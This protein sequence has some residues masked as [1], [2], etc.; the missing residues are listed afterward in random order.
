MSACN[1]KTN[2]DQMQINYKMFLREARTIE[3]VQ[4]SCNPLPRQASDSSSPRSARACPTSAIWSK[5]YSGDPYGGLPKII[6]RGGV[7]K[8]HG[9]VLKYHGG[10]LTYHGG[11][12]PT[13]PILHPTPPRWQPPVLRGGWGG[14]VGH[15]GL[16]GVGWVLGGV[17]NC[18]RGNLKHHLGYLST[19]AVIQNTIV[20]F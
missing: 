3:C 16:G 5:Q 13:P 12:K 9:G 19:T 1:M 10:V 8:Y 2:Y 6:L 14:G 17:G 18:N 7:L 11:N 20:E 15:I 4:N